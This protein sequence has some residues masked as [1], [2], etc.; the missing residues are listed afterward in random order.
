[1]GYQKHQFGTLYLD[2]VP[3]PVAQ[4]PTDIGDVPAYGGTET[5]SIGDSNPGSV[6]T[7]IQPD[8]MDILIADRVLLS[9]VSWNDLNQ[10]GFVDGKKISIDGMS[11]RC[12]LLR[13]GNDSDT[14]NEWDDILDITGEDDGLWHWKDMYFWG[15]EADI[16]FPS[17]R[18]IR[19]NYVARYWGNDYAVS[20]SA[21]VG[22]RPALE[23]IDSGA[24]PIGKAVEL[25]GLEFNVAATF[26]FTSPTKRRTRVDFRP[27]LTHASYNL[28][29]GIPVNTQLQMY[30]LL[31]DGKPIRPDGKAKYQKGAKI[32]LTDIFFGSEYLITWTMRKSP[33]NIV[34]AH[35][36]TAL[37]T[38]IPKEDMVKQGY[39]KGVS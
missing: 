25:E 38:A 23:P 17:S 29:A 16:R 18:A 3:K 37:I 1:M 26:P 36:D 4:V 27:I 19:G 21:I 7:W 2:G 14:P 31:L 5:I 10:Q 28:F 24:L 33:N 13:V 9:K 20:R 22:F 11:F 35:A 6:I 34:Y 30:T 15:Q 12:R 8:G 39:L 32:S